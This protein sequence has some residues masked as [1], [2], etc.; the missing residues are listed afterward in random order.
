MNATRM[1]EAMISF[2]YYEFIKLVLLFY[3]RQLPAQSRN[4]MPHG[5]DFS[6]A[7]ETC[8]STSDWSVNFGEISF[9]HEDTGYPLSGRHQ[10]ANCRSCHV[11]LEFQRIGTACLDCH[12][13]VHQAEL[14][15]RCED[16]HTPQ[17]WENRREMFE[18]HY[19]A[20]FPLT[21][22]HALLD[23]QTCH[24][25][26]QPGQF[27]GTPAECKSCHL[28]NFLQTI[29]P[30]HSQAGFNLDCANCHTSSNWQESIFDHGA[31][32]GFPLKGRHKKTDCQSCHINN[33]LTGL[34]TEC[35][36]CHEA[37]YQAATDPGHQLAGFDTNCQNCHNA[38]A[39]DPST[40]AHDQQTGFELTGAHLSIN[41]SACHT[42]G[43]SGTAT[44]CISCHEADYNSATNP[45][46]I[47]GSFPE[48]C[49]QC[50]SAKAWKPATFE[51]DKSYF[52][53][54]SGAHRGE[55]NNCADCHV[56]PSDYSQFECINCHEHRESKMNE[57]HR[58]RDNYVYNS[59][60]C[61]NCHPRGKGDD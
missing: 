60:A 22:R 58:N 30:T 56:S 23:C 7:C 52:P 50:H 9:K 4:G 49:T 29:N 2:R 40:W 16:C 43:F 42:A 59:Q 46:H 33:Q 31:F 25:S 39:F 36:S 54:Y 14:G 55:W 28:D 21:G 37:D 53:I 34:P 8:H 38:S 35:V 15:S 3:S 6:L 20:N 32:S 51:H 10:E 1:G 24:Q 61:Y 17:S 12:Q 45:N 5:D 18:A 26:Q 44:Q 48:D 13:D 57:E 19:K 11:S 41:C 47:S 27:A